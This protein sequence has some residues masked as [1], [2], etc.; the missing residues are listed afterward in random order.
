M[1][2]GPVGV[3][4]HPHGLFLDPLAAV[5]LVDG[6][7]EHVVVELD[8]HPLVEEADGAARR[9]RV[10]VGFADPADAPGVITGALPAIRCDLVGVPVHFQDAL[11]VAHLGEAERL[12]HDPIAVPG[13]G[14]GLFQ[15]ADKP[16]EG[17]VEGHSPFVALAHHP[18]GSQA[19]DHLHPQ[20]TDTGVE[21]VGAQWA[22]GA[23]RVLGATLGDG[24]EGVGD[25]EVRVLTET[26]HQ[27]QLVAARVQVE[28]VPVI[29]VRIVGKDVVHRIGD[30]VDQVLVERAERHG[31]WVL[32][33]SGRR[34]RAVRGGPRC[35]CRGPWSPRR[36]R[37]CSRNPR[38]PAATGGPR[39]G[40]RRPVRGLWRRRWSKSMTLISARWPTSS[41]PRSPSP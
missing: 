35:L 39:R 13:E 7:L 41:V 16:L 6:D 17:E 15:G 28:V 22:R 38:P 21:T 30:L 36:R 10:G 18:Q 9:G 3:A 31:Q 20:R 11:P 37:W 4:P 14:F 33:L 34:G 29:E 32:G 23:H 27:E 12:L 19:L 25:P 2:V 24:G 40:G 8:R 26:G 1:L 5:V